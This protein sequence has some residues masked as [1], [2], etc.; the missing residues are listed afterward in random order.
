MK[1][2]GLVGGVAS[3]KSRVAQMLVELGAGLVDAD[4]AGHAVLAED[5]DVQR[6]LRERWGDNVFAADGTVNRAAVAKRVFGEGKHAAAE[7]RFLEA[8]VHPRIGAR[9]A[10]QRDRLTAE[11]RSAV[12]VDA[13]LLFE[14][15]WRPMCDVVLFVDTP[16]DVRLAR[17]RQRGW[18]EADFAWREAAQWPVEEKRRHAD[19][20]I[21]NA[22][23]E[24][25][26]RA[27]VAEFWKRHVAPTNG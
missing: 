8:L 6:A 23:S 21:S 20:T 24:A 10:A 26:L 22:G 16:R 17:A 18:S 27:A 7:R 5:A 13:A 25:E 1:T 3:G 4:R 15:N 2:I 14:A 11:G 9:L 19:A 12:V